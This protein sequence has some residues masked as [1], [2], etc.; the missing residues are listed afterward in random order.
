MPRNFTHSKV[1]GPFKSG[2]KVIGAL[3][4]L[5][6]GFGLY[7]NGLETIK[8]AFVIGGLGAAFLGIAALIPSKN[9]FED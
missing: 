4:L 7:Q 2:C 6:A 5:F 1:D 3:L 8:A 9:R